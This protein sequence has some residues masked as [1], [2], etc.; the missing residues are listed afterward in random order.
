MKQF[1][2]EQFTIKIYPYQYDFDRK[3]YYHGQIWLGGV[4]L[5]CG[6]GFED[7]IQAYRNARNR[8]YSFLFESKNPELCLMR[9]KKQNL[10]I[11]NPLGSEKTRQNIP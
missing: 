8:C 6:Y 3:T 7:S 11:V 2:V 5:V 10:P 4:L 1:K 9:H